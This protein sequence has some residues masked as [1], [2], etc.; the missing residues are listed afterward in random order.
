MS[1]DAA[2]GNQRRSSAEDSGGASGSSPARQSSSRRY[3]PGPHVL[4]AC[5]LVLCVA[6]IVVTV[7]LWPSVD[8]AASAPVV[9]DESGD[10]V[11]LEESDDGG[12]ACA[13]CVG[14]SVSTPLLWFRVSLAD[15]QIVLLFVAVLGALGATV[16]G[17]RALAGWMS[18]GGFSTRWTWWYII[19]PVVGAGLALV[20]YIALVAGL[21]GLSSVG[22]S[23]NAWG[24]GAIGALTGLFAEQA[25]TKLSDVA[26]T[27]FSRTEPNRDS[28][29]EQQP[30]ENGD[31]AEPS[32]G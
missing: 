25:L 10:A 15:A 22:Q 2:P 16:D 9:V 32:T 28:N 3:G 5:L 6:A 19:R 7:Q 27:V 12:G 17:L 14:G 29:K 8:R 4:G 11:A 21:L 24:A 13:G 1:D 30:S 20:V 31:P 18:K 23:L 26:S